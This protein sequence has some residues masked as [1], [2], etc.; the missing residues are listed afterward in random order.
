LREEQMTLSVRGR[1]LPDGE[2]VQWWIVDGTLSA[3][4]VNDAETV[5]GADGYG[6][7]IVSGLVDAHCHV[8]LRQHGAIELDEAIAQA[9]TERDAGA[10]L[11]RDAGSP[12]DTRSFDDHDDPAPHH[13]RGPASGQAEALPARVRHRAGG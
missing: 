13:P 7:W 12:T 5:F 8:G 1:G 6:G 4:P 11:L 9:E 10:L 3:E 2:P